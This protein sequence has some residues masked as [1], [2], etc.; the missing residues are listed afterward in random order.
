MK[1][2]ILGITVLL[3]VVV[4][5]LAFIVSCGPAEDT[6]I[7]FT[8]K[9]ATTIE[10]STDGSPATITLRA[11][12]GVLGTPDTQTVTKKGG[13]ITLKAIT[14]GLSTVD[15]D[16]DKYIDI[17]G[18]VT[19]GKGNKK[20][21]VSLGSGTMVFSALSGVEG[22]NPAAPSKISVIDE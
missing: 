7:A 2:R 20:G 15:G 3:A 18:T 12:V 14:Y 16:P 8:N 22:G 6:E 13:E 1:N 9:T 4:V 21:G 10:I 11:Q 17:T 19:L 5:G